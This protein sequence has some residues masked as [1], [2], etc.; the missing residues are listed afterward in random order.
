MTL[1]DEGEATWAL[2]TKIQHDP[3]G[4]VTKISQGAYTLEMLNR[5]GHAG[6][7]PASTPTYD[8]GPNSI[9]EESDLPQTEEESAANLKLHPFFELIGCLWWLVSISRPDLIVGV[10][11]ASRYVSRPSEK[12]WLWL[13]RML[14]YLKGTVNFGLIYRRPKMVPAGSGRPGDPYRYIPQGVRLISGA[15]DS[16]FA[17]APKAKTTLGFCLKICN[18]LVE[19]DTKKSTRVLDSSTDAE[20]T[21]LVLL[22][23]SNAWWRD[24]LKE[25]GL[26]AVNVPTSVKE[27]N[28]SA[29]ILTGHGSARR[30]RHFDIA[31]YKLKDTVQ[32]GD[33][34][35]FKVPT[36]ENE[37]DFFTKALPVHSFLKHR[38]TLMGSVDDQEYF[39][40]Q[41]PETP[42][43]N[44]PIR[45]PEISA[46]M[47]V[48]AH[49]RRLEEERK[50]TVFYTVGRDL[51]DMVVSS[52][53]LDVEIEQ[54]QFSQMDLQSIGRSRWP[55]PTR[56][57]ARDSK[58]EDG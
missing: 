25:M 9:M 41:D 37:A 14:R 27:D 38:T 21:A 17:D 39:E 44:R 54:L 50:D 29:I 36:A 53:L 8:Q 19:Y 43:E 42:Q 56:P 15:A 6:C 1:T 48:I 32:F 18:N 20:C 34:E 3:V 24:F 45:D 5:F 49:P 51:S 13:T 4:G 26:F 57:R 12:L 2:K 35:L 11:M 55:G 22:G 7:K 47:F 31:F 28:T 46:L 40:R 30:S 16:S 58:L 52:D 23:H 33:L 10:H